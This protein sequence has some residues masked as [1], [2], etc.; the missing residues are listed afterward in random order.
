MYTFKKNV[1]LRTHQ[2]IVQPYSICK[3]QITRNVK[4]EVAI[5]CARRQLI[6]FFSFRF[7]FGKKNN[8]ELKMFLYIVTKYDNEKN[9]QYLAFKEVFA[10][11]F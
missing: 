11:L 8:E 1:H 3:I 5:D 7:D 6:F 4:S 2:C 9:I 10:F